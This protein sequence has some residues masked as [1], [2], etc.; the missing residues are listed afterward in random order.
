MRDGGPG[1]IGPR[2][3]GRLW[4]R[5][6]TEALNYRRPYVAQGGDWGAAV[7]TWL[8]H[9]HPVVEKDDVKTGCQAL[10][11]NMMV[12]RPG[13]DRKATALTPEETAWLK[14]ATDERAAKTAYQGIQ[15]TKPQS[16]GI[17]L[18]DSPAGLAAWIVEKFHGWS[19]CG[20]D[21]RS[22]FSMDTLLDNVMVYWLNGNMATATWLYRGVREEDARLAVGEKVATPTAFMAF[23][24]DLAPPP[25]EAW[26]ER[27]YNLRR[28]RAQPRG[29][30]FAALE[31]PDLLVDDIRDFV[32]PLRFS[33]A[34]D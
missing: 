9:D 11:L 29:G 10:H 15:N 31:E 22:R 5:L 3:I 24:A 19:D 13:I 4:H 18:T 33:A 16:L 27:A 1:P 8:A 6:M 25:P 2:A 34:N 32:R 23:P 28:Y 12:F 17:G 20:G 30:H 21:P 26:V 7:S 14:A